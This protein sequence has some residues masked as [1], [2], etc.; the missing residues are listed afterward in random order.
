MEKTEHELLKES[1]DLIRS[2]DSVSGRKGDSTNWEALH[3]RITQILKEQH[4]H[5]YPTIKQLRL[6]KLNK[7]F[8]SD[9]Y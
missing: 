2:F 5:L 3:N 9:E 7:I 8:K 1:N 6:R 4:Q